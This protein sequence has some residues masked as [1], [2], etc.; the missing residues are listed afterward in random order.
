MID[1]SSYQQRIDWQSVFDSGVR[2]AYIKLGEDG[3]G[4]DPDAVLNIH[5]ARA[6]GVT[7]GWYW[8]AHPGSHTAAESSS[9]FLYAAHGH[10]LPGDLP[11][12]LDLEV[13]EGKSLAN[14]ASWKGEWFAPVDQAI[15][16]RAVF[17]SFR[18]F[19][20]SV[21][22]TSLYPDRPVWGA[23]PGSLTDAERARWSFWQY[24]EST[25]PGI[26]GQ[27]DLDEVLHPDSVPALPA[28]V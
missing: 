25:V 19:L 24:G 5:A 28:A 2:R 20:N 17:Y 15:G 12:A 21:I 18:Y 14:L 22:G 9:A 3:V 1:V 27:V 6:V 23:H 4:V 16:T 13:T 8:F 10:M 26:V 11:P 7:P